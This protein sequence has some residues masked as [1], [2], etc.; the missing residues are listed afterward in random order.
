LRIVLGLDFFVNID[1]GVMVSSM[2]SFADDDTVAI[3]LSANHSAATVAAYRPTHP[4][5]HGRND[6]PDEQVVP[7][8][9]R[10]YLFQT[11]CQQPASAR[12]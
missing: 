11:V 4:P 1:Y 8:Q 7:T 12:S 6:I 3:M 9:I 10:L 5:T 2:L